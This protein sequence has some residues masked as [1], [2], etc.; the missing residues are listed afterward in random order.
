M[1]VIAENL[2]ASDPDVQA[3]LAAGDRRWIEERTRALVGRGCDAVDV[4]AGTFGRSEPEVLEW[5]AEVVE[6]VTELPLALDSA[7][8][9]VLTRVGRGRRRAPIF[10]SIDVDD[11]VQGTLTLD[12]GRPDTRLV[13]QLR[14][15]ARLPRSLDDRLEWTR[16]V[17]DGLDARSLAVERIFVDAVMLPWGD[18]LE[19]GRELFEFVEQ[20]GRRWPGLHTLVGLS[21]V[22]YGHRDPIRLHALWLD[23]LARAGLGAVLLD[24]LDPTCMAIARRELG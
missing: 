15:G 18:D 21:N 7:S 8:P 4:N 24:V 9:D 3:A 20:A 5:L 19:A 13:V 1:Y 11:F 17:L 12:L 2:N 10:N 14:R 16:E 6:A 23:G 22:S